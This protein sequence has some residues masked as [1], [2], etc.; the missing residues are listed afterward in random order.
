MVTNRSV[1]L[2]NKLS[3]HTRG[4]R[5]PQT[6]AGFPLSPSDKLRYALSSPLPSRALVFFDPRVCDAP[7]QESES[8]PARLAPEGINV[9]EAYQTLRTDPTDSFNVFAG[10][11]GTNWLLH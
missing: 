11:L 1:D 7:L 8:V 2:F 10:A 5:R 9:K 4:R 3:R 6:E